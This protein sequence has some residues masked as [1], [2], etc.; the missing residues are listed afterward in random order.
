MLNNGVDSATVIEGVANGRAFDYIIPASAALPPGSYQ[1]AEYFTAI[2]PTTEKARGATGFVE[3]MPNL[4]VTTTPTEAQAMVTLLVA[5][6]KQFASSTTSSF[7]FSG[8][9]FTRDS[10]ST[11]QQQLTYWQSR[12]IAEKRREKALRGEDVSGRIRLQFVQQ[13]CGWRPR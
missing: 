9:S 10:I 8:Q 3:V 5:V 4:A 12:V 2:A 11:Y 13:E 7:S 6:L 1:W